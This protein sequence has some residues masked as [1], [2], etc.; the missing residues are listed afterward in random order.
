MFCGAAKISTLVVYD[1]LYEMLDLEVGERFGGGGKWQEMN[2]EWERKF[3]N[4]GSL[5]V[6]MLDF[7][8]GIVRS[9]S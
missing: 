5:V 1:W 7:P 9:I 3:I 4:F 8:G 2:K 6:L